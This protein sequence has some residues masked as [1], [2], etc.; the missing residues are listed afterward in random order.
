MFLVF[1]QMNLFISNVE[2]RLIW[3]PDPKGAFSIKSTWN[4]F[5]TQYCPVDLVKFVWKLGIPLKIS[6]FGWKLFRNILLFD[7]NIQLKNICLASI[8]VCSTD[9][10]SEDQDH[11]LIRSNLAFRFGRNLILFLKFLNMLVLLILFLH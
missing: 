9:H 3:K 7:A 8:C 1:I 11:V 2:D 10:Q 5:H 6:I 4:S